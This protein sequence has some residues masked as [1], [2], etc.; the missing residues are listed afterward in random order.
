[1]E[2]TAKQLVANF[3]Q[4][5]INSLN[6][7]PIQTIARQLASST[8]PQQEQMASSLPSNIRAL[9]QP[10]IHSTDLIL[11]SMPLQPTQPN[12]SEHLIKV[13]A[14]APC[15]GELLWA[16]NFPGFIPRDHPFVPCFDLSGTVVTA[17]PASPFQ[18][19]AHVYTR[20]PA[21]RTGN[22]REYAV[23][24]TSELAA[25]PRNL[26]W[27]EAASVPLSA[28]TAYQAL[29]V[30]GG[31]A[32]GWK[33]EAG[34]AANGTKRVL[35][36]AAAAGVGVWLVQL[37]RAAGVREVVGI[38]GPQNAE[39]V[40]GLGASEVIDY[41]AQELGEWAKENEKVDLVVD[42][43]GGKTLESAWGTVKDGGILLSVS[44]P[45][46]TAK[47]D[48]RTSKDVQDKFFIMEP[49]GWQLDEVRDLIEAGE[50]K[51]VV[52]SV[53]K[54]EQFK[55]AFAKVASGH[56]R[57]KVIIKVQDD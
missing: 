41:K 34:R 40:K 43:L 30:H 16:K 7:H 15:A 42:L 8:S 18:P 44:Q 1:M 32:A 31:L 35:I 2:I 13:L 55:E 12:T 22:A 20:T 47:P 25:K 3:S 29:F 24:L 50:A 21:T 57:G 36:T 14:T 52:D 38:A 23:A 9:L 54:L 28:L 45:P 10:D 17:P 49:D 19:G 27:E 37:A 53:W 11:T 6:P 4:Q 48:D 51:P 39:F 5:S 26:S 46:N 56:T 33:S